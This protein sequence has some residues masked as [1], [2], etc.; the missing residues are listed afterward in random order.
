MPW[1]CCVCSQNSALHHSM[2][3]T[4]AQS[5]P[6]HVLS[7]K[8]K[9]WAGGLSLVPLRL[10]G[11]SLLLAGSLL[12]VPGLA[13]ASL[14]APLPCLDL[15]AAGGCLCLG[16][17]DHAAEQGSRDGPMQHRSNTLHFRGVKVLIFT[18]LL[19]FPSLILWCNKSSGLAANSDLQRQWF[20]FL[21]WFLVGVVNPHNTLEWKELE[22]LS[23][24]ADM[25]C[26]RKS[27][28]LRWGVAGFQRRFCHKFAL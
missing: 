20:K 11:P 13:G 22:R 7:L 17:C 18:P 23:S 3:L 19:S 9:S 8:R 10:R 4:C 2:P 21:P 15:A 16:I 28:Q 25:C 6:P 27:R 24:T 12:K 1:A 14:S 26:S 5:C